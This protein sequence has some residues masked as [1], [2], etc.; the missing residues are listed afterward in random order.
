MS[1]V[2]CC[3]LLLSQSQRKGD[4]ALMDESDNNLLEITDGMLSFPSVLFA[5]GFGPTFCF[6]FLLQISLGRTSTNYFLVFAPTGWNHLIVVL[7]W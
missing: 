1:Y 4:I 2:L 7:L 6:P 5:S 3:S